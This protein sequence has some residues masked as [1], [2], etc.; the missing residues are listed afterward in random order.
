MFIGEYQYTI[1]DKKRLA[2]PPKMRAVLGKK[3]VITKGLDQCLFLYPVKEWGIQAKRISQ[4]PLTQA[5][6]RGY[7]RNM[8]A[9]AME[10][11]I[12]NLGRILVPD[13]LKTYAFLK[14]RVVVVGVY[15]RIEIWD[16][17]KWSEY[18]Q[19]TEKDVENIAERLN[20]NSKS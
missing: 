1:D 4:L 11:D 9:G 10:V 17:T 13:Y 8:L 20:S 15:D 7:S 5:D 16:E 12:D 19:K 14:K 18:T 2:V 6:A 3:A